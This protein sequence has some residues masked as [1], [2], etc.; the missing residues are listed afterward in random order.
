MG[1]L[2]IGII[3]IFAA[4]AVIMINQKFIPEAWMRIGIIGICIILG[5]ILLISSTSLWVSANK[6]G[7]ITK[8]FGESLREGHIVSVNGE[9]GVQA[10]VLSPGWSFGWWPWLY[11]LETVDNIT[12]NEGF[13]GTVTAMDG[14]PLPEGD[15]YAPAWDSPTRMI[16]AHIFLTKGGCKGPQLTVLPPGQY[17]Y[18]PKLFSINT[19]KCIDVPVGF[20]AVVRANAGKIYQGKDENKAESIN[21]V[22]LV[23]REYRGV[24]KEPLMPGKYYMHPTA[25]QII[26]VKTTKRVYSYIGKDNN[27]LNTKANK[28]SVDNSILVRSMDGFQFPVD[29]RVV[30]TIEAQNAPPAVAL[31]GDPDSDPNK[32]GFEILEQ[33]AILPSIRAILRNSAESE[34]AIQ[35]VNSRSKVEAEIFKIFKE[36]MTKCKIDVEAVYLASI[37]LDISAEGKKLMSTQTDKELAVQQQQMYKQQV[38]AENERSKQV[39]AQEAA[40]QKKG[41]QASQAAIEIEKNNADAAKNKAMGEAA[42]Y[43]QKVKALGGVENFTKLEIAKMMTE[44]F[45]RAWKGD[46]PHILVSGGGGSGELLSAFFAQQLSKQNENPE[47]K[48]LTPEKK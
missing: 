33:R 10:E 36:E 5:I 47:A 30:V 15:I 8:K 23:S 31:F 45:G 16:D 46:V 27:E 35:Y 42:A 44:A 40:N 4:I 18:N 38:L 9:R 3:F 22:P 13:I 1:S 48:K 21:G 25:Y 6:G 11:D 7:L 37:H 41:I 24:W 26:M 12:I 17:R 34:K 43:E 19:F 14:N 29:V 32:E 39:E 2:I 20:V 28:P